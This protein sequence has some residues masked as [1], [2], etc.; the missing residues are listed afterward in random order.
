MD[1]EVVVR[2][3]NGGNRGSSNGWSLVSRTRKL[4]D[5]SWLVQVSHV[6]REANRGADVLANLGCRRGNQLV[7]YEYPP[8]QVAHALLSDAMRVSTFYPSV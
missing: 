3:I 1:F 5:S 6:Y 2:S 4:L 7:I 8:V